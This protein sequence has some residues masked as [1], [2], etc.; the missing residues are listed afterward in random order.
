MKVWLFDQNIQHADSWNDALEPG[1]K[2]ANIEYKKISTSSGLDESE[3]ANIKLAK[4][5]IVIYTDKWY[6]AAKHM[7]DKIIKVAW[8]MEPREFDKLAYKSLESHIDD[9]DLILSW[10][11]ELLEKYPEKCEYIPA[12]GLFVDTESVYRKSVTKTKNISHIFSNKKIIVGHKLRHEIAEKL[13]GFDCYGRGTKKPLEKKSDGLN[14]Y[15]F[16]I[17]V[18][19]NQAKNYFTEKILDCF[20]CRTIPVYWGAPN[21]EEF[22]DKE[23]I[24]TFNTIEELENIIPNLNESLYKKLFSSLEINYKK[25]LQYYD[26]DEFIYQ[27]IKKR[28]PNV[29]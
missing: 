22:F 1:R 20:A 6:S 25:S 29:S 18:E 16:S 4:D 24:I 17:V 23:S 5:P 9:F 28:Y 21:I 8:T 13:T 7:E 15:H 27:A 11:K 2:T 26:F 12:D 14:D 19:N 3:L 10:D